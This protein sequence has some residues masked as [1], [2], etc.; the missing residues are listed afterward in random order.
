V[1]GN[2]RVY[3]GYLK[4]KLSMG[5]TQNEQIVIKVGV[6]IFTNKSLDLLEH[7]I[8]DHLKLFGDNPVDT[9]VNMQSAIAE[10]PLL[11]NNGN[12]KKNLSIPRFCK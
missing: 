3:L 10:E 1:D 4:L 5:G 11:D 6:K 12:P 8:N 7:A 2:F 9:T